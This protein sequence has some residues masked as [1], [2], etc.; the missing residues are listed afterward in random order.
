MRS[1]NGAFGF[2]DQNLRLAALIRTLKSA[3]RTYGHSAAS[4]QRMPRIRAAR[5]LLRGAASAAPR[6]SAGVPPAT[7][8]L[9]EGLQP[10]AILRRL[11]GCSGKFGRAPVSGLRSVHSRWICCGR[12]AKPTSLLHVCRSLL[13]TRPR[14]TRTQ[15][16]GAN[17]AA[18]VLRAHSLAALF[19]TWSILTS[20]FG[21][22]KS[23]RP[24]VHRF[25]RGGL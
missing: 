5:R 10:R 8:D 13:E 9:N 22:E 24:N 23:S 6:M 2:L 18:A 14:Q 12:S 16:G 25:S 3:G 4:R 20:V 15:A 19:R 17:G 21:S 7:I 1:T 11:V